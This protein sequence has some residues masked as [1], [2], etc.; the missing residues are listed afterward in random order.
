MSSLVL[1]DANGRDEPVHDSHKYLMPLSGPT[2]ER[3][4]LS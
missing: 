2:S 3:R 1:R 4:N